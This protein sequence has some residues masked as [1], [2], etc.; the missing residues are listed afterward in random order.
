V[1][2]PSLIAHL[3][4]RPRAG[5]GMS[6]SGSKDDHK[7]FTENRLHSAVHPILRKMPGFVPPEGAHT[8]L[9]VIDAWTD[10]RAA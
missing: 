7:A 1:G 6:T 9:G 5:C 8:V 2:P 10:R 4:W 3:A